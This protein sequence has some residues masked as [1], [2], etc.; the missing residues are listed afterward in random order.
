MRQTSKTNWISFPLA[1]V[2]ALGTLCMT[3]C[4]SSIGG[5]TLPSPYYLYDD[6]EYF[7]P[8][9]EFKL[10][11]EAAAMKAFADGANDDG[12]GDAESDSP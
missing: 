6:V 7:A 5:Q 8:G 9:P 1:G 3:G 12:A 4:Q 2:I 11:R 10:A